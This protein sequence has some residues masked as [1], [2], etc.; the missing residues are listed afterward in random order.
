MNQ[1]ESPLQTL[2]V[3]VLD[4]PGS[5]AMIINHCGLS[6]TLSVAFCYW[7]LNWPK[8]IDPG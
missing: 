2:I 8:E 6:A 3:F 5:T 7:N 4:F 1:E